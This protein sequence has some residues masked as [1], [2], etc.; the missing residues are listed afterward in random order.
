MDLLEAAIAGFAARRDAA[1][2]YSE[3]L[4]KIEAQL[5]KVRE[6]MNTLA[7]R[8]AMELTPDEM[9]RQISA[10][11]AKA[12]AE[13]GIVIAQARGRIDGAV[14]DMERLA[15]VIAAAREQRRRLAWA[16]GGG[17]LAGM[18]LWSVLPGVILRA[19]PQGWHM[20]EAMAAHIIGEPTL[21]EAGSR[22]MRANSPQ[23]WQTIVVAAEVRRENS[24]TIDACEQA[25]AN[26]G[27]PV[28]CTIRIR[29]PS[30]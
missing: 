10:A 27:Q 19:L 30:S 26:T 29:K 11:G 3:T 5:G 9:A 7:R 15:G 14:R 17:L 21:W 25:A 13:D 4:G 12:R 22:L 18:L 28:R 23:A 16:A 8:P 6:A 20:P 1:P 2:D 24:E